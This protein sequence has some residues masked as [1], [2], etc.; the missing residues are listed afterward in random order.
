MRLLKWLYPGMKIKRWVFLAAG[1]VLLFGMGSALL[2]AEAGLLV[3]TV[4]LF[5][6]SVGIVTIVRGL[7]GMVR[8]L[9]DV[10]SPASQK[11]DL[12]DLVFQRRH[13][14][15]GPKVVTIGGGTGLSTLLHGLKSYTTNVTAIVTVADDGGSSGRL[16]E[17]FG[18]LPPGD[19]RNC[20]V[21]L[22]DAEPLMQQLF[23]YRFAPDS[24]LHGHNFGNLFITAMT[25]ITGDFQK[26]VQA[27][28]KVLAIRGHVVPST[29]TKVRLVAEHTNGSL[30]VGE[31]KIS[32][33][34]MAIRRIY[35]EPAHSEPTQEALA[36]IAEA[37]A[38]LLGP[39]SLYTSIIPNLLVDGL[40]D[41]VVQSRALKIYIC[42]VMTQFRETAGF[43]ASD[44]VRTL[45][46]HTSP[47]ILQV[48]I[49]NTKPVPTMLL[50]KY[51]IEQAFPVEADVEQIRKLGYQALA[52]DVISTQDYVRHDPD[53][54]ARLIIQLTVGSRRTSAVAMPPPET[55]ALDGP[56]RP[57][58]APS[59]HAA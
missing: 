44:H 49:V 11:R 16:R 48:C 13:L 7:V 10:V 56:L 41:A 25:Q 8:S 15:K 27:S 55:A 47:G 23:Q 18:M 1:G 45:V 3:R 38:I 54:L 40:T 19:I 5:F 51:R 35:L 24:A 37:D 2:T 34:P 22:A 32:Q 50:E 42:N 21:A 20:L 17:E 4:S 36:A 39:G 59:I 33:A 12:V 9:L 30:T 57:P 14:E 52:G 46:Q 26:A 58:H 28:S 43:K 31:S 29:C 6:L 53:R